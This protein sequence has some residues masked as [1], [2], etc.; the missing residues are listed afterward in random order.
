MFSATH[1]CNK[2]CTSDDIESNIMLYLEHIHTIEDPKKFCKL[3]QAFSYFMIK[4]M[5]ESR[6]LSS[7]LRSP[8]GLNDLIVVIKKQESE[9]SHS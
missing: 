4:V 3:K 6:D 1:T 8:F 9:D 7:T 2:L 5:E